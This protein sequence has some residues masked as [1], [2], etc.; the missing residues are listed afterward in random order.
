M[1]LASAFVFLEEAFSD[2]SHLARSETL[3]YWLA[4][5]ASASAFHCLAMT[6]NARSS[7]GVPTNS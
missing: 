1:S 3:V 7:S 5:S 2:L 4:A 6:E